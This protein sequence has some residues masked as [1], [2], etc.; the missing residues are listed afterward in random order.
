MATVQSGPGKI[1]I[2]E[3]FLAGED[4]VAATAASRTFGG[5]GLRVIGEGI[6]EV[7]SGIT[8]GET[9]PNLNGV[10]YLTTTDEDVHSCGVTTAKC[11]DIGLMAPF[12]AEC[13]VQFNTLL[14]KE[15]FFGLTDVNDDNATLETL[16]VHGNTLTITLTASDVCG[17]LFASEMT[18]AADWFMVYNG[19]TTVG[20]TVGANIDAND[21]AVAG[22]F[23]ILRLEVDPNGTARWYI[24]GV[25]KQTVA[26]A[27]STTTDLACMAMVESKTNA[28]MYAK[29]DFFSADAY[30]DWTV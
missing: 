16:M 20:E 19:G 10:G 1:T 21:D 7:D 22:E 8:V 24:D 3:E 18:D 15:F 27:V 4:I 11:F 17:F 28:N 29:V 14:T 25:L 2:F 9:D 26:G 12:V 13:R 5:S 6:A 30:R 23:Q